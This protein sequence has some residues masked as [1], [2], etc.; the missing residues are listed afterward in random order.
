VGHSKTT[1]S[2]ARKILPLVFS[3]HTN[4]PIQID[5]NI[6]A[7]ANNISNGHAARMRFHRL[8]Q[9]ME[10]VT[11]KHRVSKT[12]D[13][14]PEKGKAKDKAGRKP[15]KSRK[16]KEFAM[17]HKLADISDDEEEP[18]AHVKARMRMKKEMED[19]EDEYVD[20]EAEEKR[21]AP[22]RIKQEEYQI[23]WERNLDVP[24]Q[25][26]VKME[27]KDDQGSNFGEQKM[28]QVK[29]ESGEDHALALLQKVTTQ[30]KDE[31][32]EDDGFMVVDV[33]P[34]ALEVVRIK[35]EKSEIIVE[36]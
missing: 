30:I 22:K 8:R 20:S 1:R 19:S 33:A 35:E 25:E 28:K 24:L 5:W 21:A 2:Q 9:A 12:T 4:P 34:T 29:T 6:V 36:V 23:A 32:V 27:S 7:T 15:P 26:N 18:L 16:A 3:K 10:G 17:K 13:D 11:T 14:V 31:I